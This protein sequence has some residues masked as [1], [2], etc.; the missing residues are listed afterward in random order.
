MSVRGADHYH[1]WVATISADASAREIA[2]QM[3]AEGLGSLVVVADGKPAGIITDRDLMC[4]TI[5]VG[6]DAESTTARE[7][8]SHPLVTIDPA[9]PLDRVVT[10][11]AEH[12]IR[13]V[14]VT[15]DGH[16]VGILSF[17]DLLVSLNDE[18][19]DL[20]EGGRRGFREAQR[21]A[22]A[23]QLGYD[24]ETRLRDLGEQIER[25]GGG[26]KEGLL[27]ELDEMRKRIRGRSS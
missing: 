18:L 23:R 15:R 17:D 19:D 6:A 1:S 3:R 26:A 2:E 8:M 13:R 14:P 10:A 16:L 12:G 11:M 4:R 7:L 20:V 22:R 24:I 21:S 27:A 5:A 25:L 9:D